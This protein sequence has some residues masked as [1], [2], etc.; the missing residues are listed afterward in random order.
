[1]NKNKGTRAWLFV[2]SCLFALAMLFVAT[3]AF[4][5]IPTTASS[6]FFDFLTSGKGFPRFITGLGFTLLAGFTLFEII[7]SAIGMRERKLTIPVETESG[8]GSLSVS[9]EAIKSIVGRCVS[10]YNQ[11]VSY[12]CSVSYNDAEGAWV[13]LNVNVT[14]DNNVAVLSNSVRADIL[15]EVSKVAGI[16]LQGVRI[17]VEDTVKGNVKTADSSERRLN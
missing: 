17:V 11:I 12:N 9:S 14:C 5:I 10:K 7:A 15:R 6:A 2:F 4:R 13:K 3:V 1:M 8:N 16:T